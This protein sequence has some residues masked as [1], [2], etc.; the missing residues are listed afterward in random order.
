V[1]YAAEFFLWY[2]EEAVR[3][4]LDATTDGAMIAKMSNG[5]QAR[6]AANRF[7]VQRGIAPEFSLRLADA[8]TGMRMGP[9]TDPGAQLGPVVSAEAVD[10]VDSLVAGAVSAGVR[11]IAGAGCW[12]TPNRSTPQCLG[13]HRCPLRGTHGLRIRRN[14]DERYW[15]PGR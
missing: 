10:K 8:M 7:Y 12:S 3:V 9:G 14:I 4:E 5:V 2:T 6:T 13:A 15:W 1:N 11:A